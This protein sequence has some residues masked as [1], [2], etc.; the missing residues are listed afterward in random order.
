[1]TQA[2]TLLLR[3]ARLLDPSQGLDQL[4]DLWIAEGKIHKI[5]GPGAAPASDASQVIEAKGFWVLPSFIDAHVHLREPGQEHK[6]TIESGTRAAAA[7]GYTAVAC[8]AN[9]KPVNDC[10]EVTQRILEIASKNGSCRVFPVGAITQG[11]KGERLAD[12]EA[13]FHA[14]ARGISDDGMTL[15]N[16]ALLRQAM[17]IA[18]TLNIP[19]ISHAEDIHLAHGGVMNEGPRS[20]ALGL[21]GNPAAAEEITIARDIALCRLTRCPTHIAHLSTE[22]GLEHVKRAK[23]AGLPVSA[24]VAP[25]HLLLTENDIDGTD[26]NFKMAPPLRSTLDQRAVLKALSEGWIDMIATDHAPH[27]P[28]D[29]AGGFLGAANGIL[30]VQSAAS[31]TYSLVKDGSLPLGRWI[32]ALTTAPARL[33][34]IPFGTLKPNASADLVVFDPN[35]VWTLTAETLLSKSTNSPFLGRPLAG[36]V[37][38]TLLG[39]KIV[40]SASGNS[41]Y[42][43]TQ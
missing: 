37:L 15:M 6:E 20:R 18:R 29:K 31:L 40:F 27:T 36:R 4:G 28:K 34:G 35:Q 9:T 24:E 16:S 10:A 38:Y 22:T 39:G 41:G 43:G 5:T 7:G 14:G 19:V 23:E 8:M 11:L 26:T 21:P 17:E 33:L 12:I 30:G 25:H 13:M 32:E 3:G 42:D 2:N 1:M